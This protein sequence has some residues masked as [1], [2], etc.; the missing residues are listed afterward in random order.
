MRL[1]RLPLVLGL[2]LCLGL[3]VCLTQGLAQPVQADERLWGDRYDVLVGQPGVEVTLGQTEN[4]TRQ[5]GFSL[6]GGV[7][8]SQTD[9]VGT[10]GM[11]RSGK[12]ALL[13]TWEIYL[14]IRLALDHC[15]GLEMPQH[16]AALNAGLARMERFIVAN[17]Y[18][19][20]TEA[21]IAARRQRRID[22]LLAAKPAGAERVD[23]SRGDMKDLATRLTVVPPDQMSTELDAAMA[24]PRF[25]V[26][27]PCL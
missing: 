26:M 8:L 15:Q 7:T 11:D 18:G 20:W 17:S 9:G 2:S 6:P 23:C 16:A 14:M 25:P 24:I 1:G 3:A 21:A 19:F 27:N 10:M 13:C 5:R 12:G 4:G 22:R